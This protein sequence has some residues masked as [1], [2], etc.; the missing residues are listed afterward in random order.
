MRVITFKDSQD[1]FMEA[2]QDEGVHFSRVMQFSTAPMAA[3]TALE[4][5]HTIGSAVPW[6]SLA[7]VAVKWI[8][9]RHSREI[10]ITTKDGKVVS[11]KNLTKEEFEKILERADW[12]TVIDTKK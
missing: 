7:I 8:S 2:L 3:G 5:L 12:I 1:S 9:V 11:G 4:V 6:A 10:Q